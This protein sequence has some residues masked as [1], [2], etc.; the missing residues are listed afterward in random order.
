MIKACVIF[1]LINIASMIFLM[2]VSI[3][4]PASLN[5]IDIYVDEDDDSE[6]YYYNA[7]YISKTISGSGIYALA[8]MSVSMVFGILGIVGA[9]KFQKYLVLAT[10]LWYCPTYIIMSLL[11]QRWDGAV[12][13]AIYSYPNFHLFW[14]FHKKKITKDNYSETEQH[15]CCGEYC[16]GERSD[17]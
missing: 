1:N 3:L 5:R 10:G 11:V 9:L 8:R 6:Y 12:L 15:C 16:G 2:T 17:E 7:D 4:E 14:Q 13:A